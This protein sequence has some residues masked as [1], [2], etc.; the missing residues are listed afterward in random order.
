MSV[1]LAV[2][3]RPTD[4]KSVCSQEAIIK[5]L[6]RQ[7]ETGQF[8]NCY[9]FSGPSGTGKTTIARILADKI[10]CGHGSPIEIDA[11]SNNG[12]DNVRLLIEQAGQRSIDSEYKIYIIDECHMLTNQS[13]NALLKLIE[14]PPKYTIFMFCTTELQKVPETIQNRCQQ[15]RLSRVDNKLIESR[16]KEIAD[17]EKYTYTVE[18][19]RQISKMALGSMRQAISYLDKCKDYG[20]V[21][22]ENICTVLGNFSYDVFF[23]LTNAIIDKNGEKVIEIIEDLYSKGDDLKLFTEMFF[24]FLLDLTKYII[25]KSFEIIKIPESY[26][27]KIVYTINVEN[28]EKYYNHLIDKVLELK[29]LIK[30]DSMIK[31][32]IEVFLLSKI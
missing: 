22:P 21:T 32:T 14:E 5:I 10:N 30:G 15:Y 28:P 23:D 6:E 7:L 9:L 29:Q 2:K 19:L 18:G 4:F 20:D 13:W 24:D 8:V 26:L 12:V 1:S 17:T 11:A 27:E 3:Y 16:L 25:F 31:N